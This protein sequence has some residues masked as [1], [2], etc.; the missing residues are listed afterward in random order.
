MNTQGNLKFLND[1]AQ[2]HA[3]SQSANQTD[4]QTPEVFPVRPRRDS[5][6]SKLEQKMKA[7]LP[8]KSARAEPTLDEE[9]A[10][11]ERKRSTLSRLVG[12]HA[13]VPMGRR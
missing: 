11:N 5:S 2:A 10:A 9:T 6:S 7:L 13:F 8:G 3:A 1:R 12:S 4:K